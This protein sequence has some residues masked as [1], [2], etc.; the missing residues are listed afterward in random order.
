M[1]VVRQAFAAWNRGDIE[2]YIAHLCSDVEAI[3]MGAALEGKVWRGHDEIRAWAQ[4]H[5]EVWETLLIWAEEFEQVDEE[6]LLVSGHWDAVGRSGVEMSAP[7]TWVFGFRDAK[8]A[9]WQAYTSRAAA[10]E[11]VGLSEQRTSANPPHPVTRHFRCP[12]RSLAERRA[13]GYPPG[14]GL[15]VTWRLLGTVRLLRS[16]GCGRALLGRGR[17]SGAA[18]WPSWIQRT[19]GAEQPTSI[20]TSA[21]VN[22]CSRSCRAFVMAQKDRPWVSRVRGAVAGGSTTPQSQRF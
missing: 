18:R 14:S 12:P 11:A 17:A 21:T 1:E 8:I 20:A 3:P 15:D 4:T 7:A 6:L 10:L 19:V 22:S 13:L 16:A 9:Y 2:G 5:P